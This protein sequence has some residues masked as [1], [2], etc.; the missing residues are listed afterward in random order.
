MSEN[1]ILDKLQ[2]IA[3]NVLGQSDLIITKKTKFDSLGLNSFGLVQLICAVED[4][5]DIE[6][7][8]MSIKS[9]NNVPSLLKFIKSCIDKK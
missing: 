7:P 1:E 2:E 4:E 9:V 6:I 8:N 3:R 5:F